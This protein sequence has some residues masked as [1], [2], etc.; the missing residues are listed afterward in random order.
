[1]STENRGRQAAADI[2]TLDAA[3]GVEAGAVGIDA[4]EQAVL[5]SREAGVEDLG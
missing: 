3:V 2:D 4:D 1:V 5:S